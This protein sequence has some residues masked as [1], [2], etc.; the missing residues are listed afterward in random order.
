VDVR[1][2]QSRI[3]RN[4]SRHLGIAHLSRA[5]ALAN[6]TDTLATNLPGMPRVTPEDARV[7]LRGGRRG[8]RGGRGGRGRSR[9]NRAAGGD[10]EMQRA[11][12]A[13]STTRRRAEDNPSNQRPL[14]IFRRNRGG[15]G[16]GGGR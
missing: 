11:S 1:N 2:F 12:S 9:A 4:L 3:T 7:V 6:L 13:S 15:G 10:V 14:K 8:Q 16:G 5:D